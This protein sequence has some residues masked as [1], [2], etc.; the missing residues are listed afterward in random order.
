M[1]A[2]ALRYPARIAGQARKR[3]YSGVK[4]ESL[5]DSSFGMFSSL[6]EI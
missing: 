4:N 6:P 5:F 3:Q 2:C 1:L